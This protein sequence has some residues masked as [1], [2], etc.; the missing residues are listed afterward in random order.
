MERSELEE[1]MRLL[2]SVCVCVCVCVSVCLCVHFAWRRYALLY[3]RLLVLY[4]VLKRIQL[5]SVYIYCERQQ[6]LIMSTMKYKF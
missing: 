2:L 5:I 4:M 1:I 3:E 6:I